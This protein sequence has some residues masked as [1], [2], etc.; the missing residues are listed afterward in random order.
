MGEEE[1]VVR[2][3]CRVL[4]GLEQ[5]ICRAVQGSGQKEQAGRRPKQGERMVSELGIRLRRR[6]NQAYILSIVGLSLQRQ[7]QASRPFRIDS[8]HDLVSSQPTSPDSQASP[9]F[10]KEDST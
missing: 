9:K 5:G 6:N 1:R 8:P 2:V 3:S 7:F 4:L 10:Q